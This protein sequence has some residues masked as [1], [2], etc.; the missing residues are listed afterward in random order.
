MCPLPFTFTTA[1]VQVK[2]ELPS[3]AC[4]GCRYVSPVSPVD[5]H[6]ELRLV[7]DTGW[8]AVSSEKFGTLAVPCAWILSSC[9]LN[10]PHGREHAADALD[11]IQVRGGQTYS[12]AVTPESPGLSVFHG[13]N[14]PTAMKCRLV[15]IAFVSV[16]S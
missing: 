6:R 2:A 16:A 10:V 4:T 7:S 14:V 8:F 1:P 9:P 5:D 15:G 12:A 13:P 11:R 3:T